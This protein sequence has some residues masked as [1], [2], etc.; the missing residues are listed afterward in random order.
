M[1]EYKIW[2]QDVVRSRNLSKIHFV[3]I[4]FP[5]LITTFLFW[6]TVPCLEQ[7]E[8]RTALAILA[9]DNSS[10][11]VSSILQRK[12]V[13]ETENRKQKMNFKNEH[14]DDVVIRRHFS[15]RRYICKSGLQVTPKQIDWDQMSRH[16]GV[17]EYSHESRD[18]RVPDF[19][20]NFQSKPVFGRR[21]FGT[22]EVLIPRWPQSWHKW[23]W[24]FDSLSFSR[25]LST[26]T[27]GVLPL[28][29]S[30]RIRI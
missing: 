26:S 24:M 29:R 3:C 12:V 20:T 11:E 28:L 19:D 2:S 4:T 23:D 10:R 22:K 5:Y 15:I 14:K 13:I 25:P 6:P 21:N 7:Y 27:M 30:G 8:L 18:S 1:C 17:W 9:Q 16:E